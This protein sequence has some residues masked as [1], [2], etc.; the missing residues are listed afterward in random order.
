MTDMRIGKI[1]TSTIDK[2]AKSV[3]TSQRCMK[4]STNNPDYIYML[5]NKCIKPVVK[6]RKPHKH[7]K[8]SKKH[9]K[10]RR[11]K[12]SHRVKYNQR[13]GDLFGNVVNGAN[14]FTSGIREVSPP[15]SVLPW[16][17]SFTR[18]YLKM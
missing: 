17:G 6:S 7:P 8:M 2:I 11:N 16:E 13:G 4:R 1:Y 12:K 18:D 15:P 5:G 14:V 9:M 10:K 3:R